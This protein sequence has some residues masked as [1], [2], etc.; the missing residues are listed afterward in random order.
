MDAEKRY[1]SLNTNLLGNHYTHFDEKISTRRN[2][3]SAFLKKIE[4]D[5]LIFGTVFRV[6]IL[7]IASQTF[8]FIHTYIY[9]KN[10]IDIYPKYLVGM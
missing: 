4:E 7:P 8:S 2:T 10:I 5:F 9:K 6:R 1:L 3:A